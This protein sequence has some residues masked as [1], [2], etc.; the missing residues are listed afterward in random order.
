MKFD[1][2]T[3]VDDYTWRLEPG[4]DSLQP[5]EALFDA[6]REGSQRDL[7]FRGQRDA[8][9]SINST[10]ARS[11]ETQKQIRT[12]EGVE[13]A[14]KRFYFDQLA[15][16]VP[17]DELQRSRSED[18][19]YELHRRMQQ[20]PEDFDEDCRRTG[21]LLID[22]SR[23][24]KVALAFACDRPSNDGLS[25]EGVLYIVDPQK[26]TP[27]FWKK[28]LIE[29]FRRLFEEAA[30]GS[31]SIPALLIHP[32]LGQEYLP[33]APTLHETVTQHV[34]SHS[35][36]ALFGDSHAKAVAGSPARNIFR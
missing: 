12:A 25:A 31:F 10:F 19:H 8:S 27:S 23:C 6:L 21:T 33:Y 7:L 9:W 20:H 1:N 11:D 2:M 34:I 13:Q 26:L 35:R 18:K 36:A 17:S 30:R 24:F 28:P 29:A 16:N 4:F 32:R 3:Q 22:W 14:Y 15:R 5:L